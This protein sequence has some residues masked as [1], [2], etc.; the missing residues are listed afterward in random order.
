MRRRFITLFASLSL[1]ACASALQLQNLELSQPQVRILTWTGVGKVFP[2]GRILELGVSTTVT[3]FISARSDT[4]VLSE[5]RSSLRT[6]IIEPSGGWLER[7]GKRE[8][9]PELMLRQERQQFAIYGQMQLA[10]ARAV[11]AHVSNRLVTI[12]GDGIRSV[13]TEFLFD[14]REHLLEA[15]NAVADS[16]KSGATVPLISHQ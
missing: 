3:P 16:E 4:W 9:M 11:S 14:S 1:A 5:G 12:K 10:L 8:P 15:R 2:P 13:D 6:M 7:N